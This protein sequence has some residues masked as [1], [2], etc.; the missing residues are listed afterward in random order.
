MKDAVE[1]T[2]LDK[3]YSA[4]LRAAAEAP[5]DQRRTAGLADA[6]STSGPAGLRA[7]GPPTNPSSGLTAWPR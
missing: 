3:A 7:E 4:W 6:H 5:L 1:W 2:V